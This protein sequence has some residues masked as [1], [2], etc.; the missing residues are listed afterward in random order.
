MSSALQ[1]VQHVRKMRG[2]SQ[3]HLMRGSDGG[4][5]VVKFQNNPQ[6]LRILANEMFVSR[7]GRQLG[8]PMPEAEVMEVS[9]WLIDHTPELCFDLAERRVPCTSGLHLASRFIGDPLRDQVLDFLP[10]SRQA[11]LE[12]RADFA[13]ALV[14]DKWVANCDDRQAVFAR[15]PR[16][17]RF[18]AAFID[19]GY[20]FN[21]GEWT[22]PDEP[23]RGIYYRNY[24]YRDVTGWDSFDPTLSRAESMSWFDLWQCA[25]GIPRQ[26]YDSDTEGLSQLIETLYDR[27]SIIRQLI[28]DFRD[29]S[30]TPFPQWGGQAESSGDRQVSSYP[31]QA[32]ASLAH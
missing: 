15:K 16:S 18:R 31:L 11:Q 30:R 2:G 27:R 7:L 9:Q 3:A 6:H 28:S 20:C 32:A 14:V 1:G 24:V 26:W 10:E 21:V 12:N 29:S 8:L 13:R 4:Y 23:L 5:W 17:Q 22:F 25:V 19:H